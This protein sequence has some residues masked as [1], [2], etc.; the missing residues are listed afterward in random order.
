MATYHLSLKNGKTRT[1]ESHADYILREGRYAGGKRAEELVC[2]DA[3]IPHWAMNASAFFAC[4]DLYERSNARAYNEF[5]VALPNELS[6]EDNKKLIEEFISE[7]IGNNK[8]WAYAIHSKPAAFDESEEQIH[9]H[10]MFCERIVTDGMDKAK[11]PNKFFKRYNTKDPKKGGY[12]KDTRFTGNK[13]E[14]SAS[15]SSIRK[16]WEDKINQAYKDHGIDKKVSCKSLSAQK[17]E[18]RELGDKA[19]EEYLD[20][21]P[22][23]H[24]GPALAYKTKKLLEE[25]GF[26]N[27]NI[28]STLDKIYAMSTKAFCVVMDK[29]KKAQKAAKYRYEKQLE[30]ENKE[31]SY[32]EQKLE[33]LMKSMMEKETID[34]EVIYNDI[35]ALLHDLKTQI[36][37]N[38]FAIQQIDKAYMSDA[39]IS[40]KAL[41]EVTNGESVKVNRARDM[42]RKMHGEL[43]EKSNFLKTIPREKLSENGYEQY[44]KDM[45]YY[46]NLLAATKK[47][48]QEI[49]EYWSIPE[50]KEKLDKVTDALLNKRNDDI[51]YRELF[52]K[53]REEYEQLYNKAIEVCKKVNPRVNYEIPKGKYKKPVFNRG[54]EARINSE[55]DNISS[56]VSSCRTFEHIKRNKMTVD[57][58]S[59]QRNNS[60]EM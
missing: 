49:I 7:N 5:E 47:K 17:A 32:T 24:L 29:I 55:L 52:V 35:R 13:H 42:L 33:S 15:I 23:E 30:Q 46:N 36:G 22:Q 31:K 51:K 56:L 1:G 57:L 38:N 20:R 43:T 54:A 53:T 10:I 59:K 40:A 9:A 37:Y 41:A 26:D 3:N 8:V 39:E 34:G 14:I 45:H 19:L 2:K 6:H 12:Q 44:K 11:S 27:K 28:D 48:S 50:N 58:H 25:N 21:E 4:A 18:A 60:W 16:V